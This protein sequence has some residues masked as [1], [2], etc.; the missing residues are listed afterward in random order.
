MSNNGSIRIDDDFD[1]KLTATGREELLVLARRFRGR[2]ADFFNAQPAF[3]TQDSQVR[4]L[5]PLLS[6]RNWFANYNFQFR[7]IASVASQ[8]S[9]R[10]FSRGIFT[11]GDVQLTE[12]PV[13]DRLVH[14][15]E[16]CT[17][18]REQLEEKGVLEQESTLFQQGSTFQNTLADVTTR[19]GFQYNMS[20]G[21]GQ[22]FLLNPYIHLRKSFCFSLEDML[23]IYD[24]CRYQKAWYLE[25]ISPWCAA[26]TS[27]NLKVRKVMTINLL[28]R[29]FYQLNSYGAIRFWNSARTWIRITNRVTDANSITNKH[30]HWLGIW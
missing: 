11:N 27:E 8:S 9:A 16:N 13:G 17:R 5:P 29:N 28:E 23:L 22:K 14:F 19:L 10:S 20:S 1:E 2:F 25:Q 12:A 6:T 4:L 15:Y 3:N 24:I 26:F 30:A 21:I 7:H 18:W